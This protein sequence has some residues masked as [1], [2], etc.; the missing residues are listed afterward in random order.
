M[1]GLKAN[2]LW[3]W[4]GSECTW[5]IDVMGDKEEGR[6]CDMKK[7]IVKGHM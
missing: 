5:D 6:R 4:R 1:C 2:I 7:K 3:E